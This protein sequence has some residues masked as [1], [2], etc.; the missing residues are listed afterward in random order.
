MADF[1]H[2]YNNIANLVKLRKLYAKLCK[3]SKFKNYFQKLKIAIL[4]T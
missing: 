4:K 1:G 3:I 2:V